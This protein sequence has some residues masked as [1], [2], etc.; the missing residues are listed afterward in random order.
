[1]RIS[2]ELM[3]GEHKSQSYFFELLIFKK[4]EEK[5]IQIFITLDTL[6]SFS[7]KALLSNSKLRQILVLR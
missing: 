6:F 3:T 4:L 7:K 2:I 5:V 1:M